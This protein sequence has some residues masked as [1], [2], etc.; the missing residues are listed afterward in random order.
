MNYQVRYSNTYLAHYGIL[1]QKW[2][3]RNGPPYPL[4]AEDH[5]AS[6]RKAGWRKSIKNAK[7]GGLSNKE[8]KIQSRKKRLEY[9][10]NS[11]INEQIKDLRNRAYDLAE[12]Y[13]FDG[14]DGGGGSTK[15][16][17]KA[18][19]E[20][21]K[22]WDQIEYL[23][24][25]REDESIKNTE[26]YFIDKYGQETYSNLVKRRTNISQAKAAAFVA[27]L[28]TIMGLLVISDLK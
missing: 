5:S 8:Y 16:D 15:A 4:D 26:K 25:K 7:Y 21:M 13:D 3:K 1:G 14:D 23:E 6:E 2:G 18:G 20:Y 19:K 9:E 27:G 28:W 11:K 12:K 24:Q 22:I 17:E 10:K